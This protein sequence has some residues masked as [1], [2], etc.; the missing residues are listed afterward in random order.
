VCSTFS[1]ALKNTLKIGY[2]GSADKAVSAG[3]LPHHS[4]KIRINQRR[5]TNVIGG[6]FAPLLNKLATLRQSARYNDQGFHVDPDDMEKLRI[7]ADKMLDLLKQQIAGRAMKIA[8][9]KSD[10]P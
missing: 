6:D 2:R 4:I 9:K 7:S 1:G 8:D 10:L 3:C 5:K